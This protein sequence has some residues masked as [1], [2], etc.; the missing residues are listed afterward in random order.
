MN[1]MKKRNFQ[2]LEN[3]EEE[4]EERKHARNMAILKIVVFVAVIV[5]CVAAAVLVWLR[6]RTYDSYEMKEEIKTETLSEA[7]FYDYGDA[8]LKVSKNGAIYSTVGGELIWN[9]SY[10]MNAP[11]VDICED[12]VVIGAQKGTEIY[13][14]NKQGLKGKI[15]TTRQIRAV[16]VAGQGTVA[17]MTEKNKSY[18][19]NLYDTDGEELVQGEMHIENSGYPLSMS[20]SPDAIKLAVALVDVSKG[21]ANSTVNF[22]NFGTV[23]QNEIDN[24]V[25][26]YIYEGLVI[27]RIQYLNDNKV[28]AFSNGKLLFFG[29]AQKPE[30]SAVVPVTEEIRSVFYSDKYVGVTYNVEPDKTASGDVAKE[31]E[32]SSLMHEVAVYDLKGKEVMK[33][34][35]KEDYGDVEIL[36]NSELVF[37]L[38]EKCMICSMDG[39]IKFAGELEQEVLKMEQ[40][41]VGNEYYVIFKD[42][43]Q[44]IRLK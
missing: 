30:E 39:V 34:Q 2:V 27:P 33:K 44:K 32:K 6:Y 11:I 3:S 23:G 9:Q 10:E 31:Q 38:G 22:Y 16:E 19:I 36:G 17:V 42:R 4:L 12:Y 14:L 41:G 43:V 37:T 1:E 35:Y 28:V 40:T 21:Q 20:L 5:V 7:E 26:S 18:Y 8:V 15:E 25:S 29:G 24:L 13:I